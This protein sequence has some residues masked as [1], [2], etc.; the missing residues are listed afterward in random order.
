MKIVILDEAERDLAEGFDFYERQ[1][2]GV[3][4]YF[5]DSLAADIDSLTLYAGFHRIHFGRF[6]AVFG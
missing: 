4:A 6:L 1:E 2:E 5:L 3:G